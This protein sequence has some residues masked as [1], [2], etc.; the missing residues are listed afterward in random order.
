MD[1]R[2]LG[3]NEFRLSDAPP[4]SALLVGDVVVF[5]V[6]G[7]FCATQNKCTHRQGPLS[8]GQLEG[9][10]VTCPLHG[11]QFNVCTGAVL[12]GPATEPLKTYRVIVDGA[13]GRVEVALPI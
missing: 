6:D 12:R 7:Q 8:R 11:A 13:I 9:S 4:G 10:T 1:Q 2:V 3:Y 5:N